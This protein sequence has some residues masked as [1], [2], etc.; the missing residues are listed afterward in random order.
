[1]MENNSVPK[2]CQPNALWE[3]GMLNKLFWI[4]VVLIVGAAA[5][6]R[7]ENI[8]KQGIFAYDEAWYMQIAKTCLQLPRFLAEIQQGVPVQDAFQSIYYGGFYPHITYKPS[9]IVLLMLTQMVVGINNPA[10]GAYLSAVLGM[11][12]VGLVYLTFLQLTGSRW[13]ALM[14]M[15]ITAVSGFQIYYSRFGIPYQWPAFVLLFYFYLYSR[16]RFG[17]PASRKMLF[18]SGMGIGLIQTTNDMM[19]PAVGLLF[20]FE[21][22]YFIYQ[23]QW[24]FSKV[25]RIWPFIAGVAAPLVFWDLVSHGLR[26]I[27]HATLHKGYVVPYHQELF[28]HIFKSHVRR[29]ITND[30]VHAA[31]DYL[32]FVKSLLDTEGWFFILF[33]AIGTVLLSWQIWRKKRADWFLLWIL[34]GASLALLFLYPEKRFRLAAPFFP[35]LI[36]VCG[37]GIQSVISWLPFRQKSVQV[38]VAVFLLGLVTIPA[39]PFSYGFTQL[40]SGYNQLAKDL[41]PKL[42]PG[43]PIATPYRFPVYSIYFPER[44]VLKFHSVEDFKALLASNK[45]H[46]FLFEEVQYNRLCLP[47][48]KIC[49]LSEGG[50]AK[51]GSLEEQLAPYRIATY[52]LPYVRHTPSLWESL[53]IPYESV[54]SV[55]QHGAIYNTDK[56]RLYYIAEPQQALRLLQVEAVD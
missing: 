40:S 34:S 12:T 37:I 50:W 36:L 20:L 23:H 14:T 47:P 24:R 27:F 45:V 55:I 13:L 38:A 1:M 39:L 30:E 43:E 28:S 5:F 10:A 51:V 35:L 21:L 32:Y 16:Y 15:G 44:K 49:Y 19:I 25:I 48:V 42:Q 6:L 22:G 46:Y 33:L 56:V 9:Y 18:W 41:K 8:E 3:S 29:A 17:R 11:L 26:K 7:F 2:E 31:T 53:H 4:L 54:T 52:D